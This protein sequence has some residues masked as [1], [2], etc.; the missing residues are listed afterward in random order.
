MMILIWST[1]KKLRH[2]MDVEPRSL[3]NFGILEDFNINDRF[4]LFLLLNSSNNFL[5]K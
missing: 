1:A 4:Y 3:V 2:D 5:G